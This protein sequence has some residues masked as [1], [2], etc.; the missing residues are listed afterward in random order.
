M[1]VVKEP[2]QT[3]RSYCVIYL[4]LTWL[5]ALKLGKSSLPLP[6]LLHH[7]NECTRTPVE[8]SNHRRVLEKRAVLGHRRRLRSSLCRLPR[9]PQ[10]ASRSRHQLYCHSQSCRWL[11]VR[12]ALH[13]QMDN[14]L[15][16]SNNTPHC[17]L[18]W[19]RCRFLWRLK[20][21]L[22]GLGATFWQGLLRLL[23]DSSSLSIP[24]GSH[25]TPE[26]NT[27]HCCPLVCAFG[28]CFLSCLG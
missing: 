15:D 12:R 8:R 28:L 20:Q 21:R 23:G 16:P 7:R 14:T 26:Q 11:G 27:Y 25:G 2:W 3:K 22:R 1:H 6:L 24:Q 10:N 9:F 18:G 13:Y 5:T 17:Q 4:F 19:C